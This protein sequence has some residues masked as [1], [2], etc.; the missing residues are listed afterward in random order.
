MKYA[1]WVYGFCLLWLIGC[2]KPEHHYQGYVEAENLY[3]SSPYGGKLLS[4]HVVRGQFI[5][6]GAPLFELDPAP[7]IYSLKEQEALHSQSLATLN[8]LQKPRRQQEIDAIEAQL[9]QV[10]SQLSLASIR[11][12]RNQTLYDKH[13]M[14]KDTL[15]AASERYNEVSALKSQTLANLELA[16]LGSRKDRIKAQKAAA[17]SVQSRVESLKWEIQ[18]KHPS[19]PTAGVVFDTYYRPGEYVASDHPVLSIVAPENT[20]IEFFVPLEELKNIHLGKQIYFSYENQ[21][22]RQRAKI[23]YVSP[24][25]EYMPPLVYSRSNSD[26]I[27]FRIKADILSHGRLIPGEPVMV[28]IGISN[29]H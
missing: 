15:D 14:D 9:K 21:T 2:G 28:S 18:Q 17:F 19:A 1:H 12:K 10:E 5:E 11:L 27:V 3:L 6:K 26:K 16:R 23:V 8:D 20:H 4:L 22:E 24:E 25:A 7:E 29:D 13:V